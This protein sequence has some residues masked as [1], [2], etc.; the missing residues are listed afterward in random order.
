MRFT[1]KRTAVPSSGWSASCRRKGEPSQGRLARRSAAPNRRSHGRSQEATM[2]GALDH[3]T[4]PPL[5][6]FHDP[7]R[8]FTPDEEGAVWVP[9]DESLDRECRPLPGP[10]SDRQAERLIQEFAQTRDPRLRDRLVRMHGRMVRYLAS[11]F[12]NR[13]SPQEDVRSEERR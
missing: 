1:S 12:D 11:R 7:D 8:L 3:P 2:T 5:A 4:M 10:S 13:L 9:P 6:E